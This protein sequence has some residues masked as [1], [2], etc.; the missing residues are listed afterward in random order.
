[1]TIAFP[2]ARNKTRPDFINGRQGRMAKLGVPQRNPTRDRL[3]H[4]EQQAGGGDRRSGYRCH[5]ATCRPRGWRSPRSGDP[6]LP[7]LRPGRRSRRSEDVDRNRVTR[8]GWTALRVT[9]IPRDCWIV[10]LE[11]QPE[12]ARAPACTFLHGKRME[13]DDGLLVH[14][15]QIPLD[16]VVQTACNQ[17]DCLQPRSV[18]CHFERRC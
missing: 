5:G 2:V 17:G 6:S 15:R 18:R 12:N 14:P 1:M 8:N 3:A 11:L 4:V 16:I 9:A 10:A 13:S 7:I